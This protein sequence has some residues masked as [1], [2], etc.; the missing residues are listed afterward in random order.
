MEL[1]FTL[2]GTAAKERETKTDQ[3]SEPS[4]SNYAKERQGLFASV[5]RGKNLSRQ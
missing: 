2:A 3:E 4:T 5:E 1:G